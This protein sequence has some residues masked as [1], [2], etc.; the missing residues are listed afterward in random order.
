MIVSIELE[1]CLPEDARSEHL[2]HVAR[3]QDASAPKCG[4]MK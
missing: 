1:R 4:S 2:E 3:A